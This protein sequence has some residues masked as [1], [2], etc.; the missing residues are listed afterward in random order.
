MATVNVPVG[1]TYAKIA[2]EGFLLACNGSDNVQEWVF[3]VGA[4]LES[5]S[6]API[7]KGEGMLGGYGTGDLYARGAGFAVVNS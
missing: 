2:D 4:P 6:G 7:E 5:L 1:P 3:S